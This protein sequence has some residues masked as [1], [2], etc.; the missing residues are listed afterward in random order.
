RVARAA[1][2]PRRA[3]RSSSATPA[4]SSATRPARSR[5]PARTLPVASGTATSALRSPPFGAEA[6]VVTST[7]AEQFLTVREHQGKRTWRW[8]LGTGKLKPKLRVDGSVLVTAG[9][10]DARLHR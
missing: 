8:R 2:R 7:R 9:A 6:V 10:G 4:T 3:S 1:L 5:S